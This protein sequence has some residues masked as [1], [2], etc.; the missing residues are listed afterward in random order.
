MR[1]IRH[2]TDYSVF[3][4]STHIITPV[5]EGTSLELSDKKGDYK[6]RSNTS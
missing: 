2:K 6:P 5:P 3:G 4:S 1:F